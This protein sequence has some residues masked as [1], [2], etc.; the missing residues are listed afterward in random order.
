MESPT[1]AILNLLSLSNGAPRARPSVEM[2]PT[3]A[4]ANTKATA[5]APTNLAP[6]NRTRGPT[7]RN[8]PQN[9]LRTPLPPSFAPGARCSPKRRRPAHPYSTTAGLAGLCDRAG[10]VGF[11]RPARDRQRNAGGD[12]LGRSRRRRRRRRERI[13]CGGRGLLPHMDVALGLEM[14]SVGLL[15]A[16]GAELRIAHA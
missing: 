6:T 13:A 8:I 2:A 15:Q 11:E 3:A 1:N 7:P 10:K 9:E 14:D 16:A 12:L 4:K 5:M